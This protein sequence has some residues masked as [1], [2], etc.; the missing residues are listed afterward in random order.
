MNIS[1]IGCGYVGIVTGVCLADKGHKVYFFD[2]DREKLKRFI[3]GEKII[4][5]KGLNQ[6]FSSAKK[7]GKIFITKDLYEAVNNSD[8]SFICVGTPLR[9]KKINLNQI[10][11][12]TQD[13][14]KI[15]HYKKK[16]ALIYKSTIPP[17][18]IEN[19]CIP[20]LQ[21]KL[22][23][24]LNDHIK[25]ISNPEF[26]REG[27][28]VYDFENPDRIV[29]GINNISSK[30]IMNN[31]Y[32]KY[33]KKAKIIY[34]DIKTSEFIKYFSNSFFSLLISYSNEISNL[35]Q[36]LNIDFIDVL[37]AFKLDNRLK[38]KKKNLPDMINYLKPGIGYGGSCFPKDVKTFVN[39]SKKQKNNLTILENVDKINL[40]QP[41][42]IAD[43]ILKEFKKKRLKKILILGITFKENTDDIRNST[44]IKLMNILAKYNFDV[45][46]YDP[47]FSKKDFFKMK[48]IFNSKIK[49]WDKLNFKQKFDAIIINNKSYQNIKILKYYNQ[50]FQTFIYDSRRILDKKKFKN[51]SG[52]SINYFKN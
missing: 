28:A 1:I 34:V 43:H 49:Y 30:K 33:R 22:K 21:K 35:S 11:S 38:S 10:K 44:S 37:N 31:I 40:N 25:I 39:F 52:V 45:Y 13:F 14:T 7:K 36:K 42:K 51:Y 15:L 6:K 16:H 46:A 17:K 3:A 9:N 18:T 26:L 50:K 4:F 32:S 12:V 48:K 2:K 29:V 5:E 19:F 23:K 8:A 47:I 20:I 24:K 27:N 41:S